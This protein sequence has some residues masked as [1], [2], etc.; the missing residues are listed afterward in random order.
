MR[1]KP[2]HR[3]RD[4]TEV[5]V[6][7]ALADRQ[8]EGMTVFELRSRV[9]VDI[10]TLEDAL[11]ELKDDG[12]IEA[13]DD[14]RRTLIFPDDRAVGPVA[15]DDDEGGNVFDQLRDRLPF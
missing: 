10:D 1:A 15:S 12:L 13:T 7:D 2:E 3:N 5:A 6:L 11:G 14:G 8:E 9:D 4:E